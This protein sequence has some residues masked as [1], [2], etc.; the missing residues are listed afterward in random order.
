MG[1]Q[2]HDNIV[3][4]GDFNSDLFIANNNKL[5]ETMML[6]SLVNIISKPT[7]ITEHSNNLLDPI[8]ISDTINYIYSDVLK[9]PSE[10]SDHDASVAFLQCP[11]S[12]AGSFKREVWLYDQVDQQKCIDKLEM[13]DW[14][15][16]LCQ[17]DDID[18]MCNQFTKTFLELAREC[19]PTNTVTVRLGDKRGSLVK[20]GK[21]Y[22]SGTDL[23]K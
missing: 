22:V 10:I 23:V 8:I 13:V 16:L 7:R 5:I 21:K 17:F 11:K 1:Y 12:V 14:I 19:I 20:S 3:I 15:T 6:F 18:D 9:I 2:V 4:L